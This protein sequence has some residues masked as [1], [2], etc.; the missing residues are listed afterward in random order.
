MYICEQVHIYMWKHEHV[1]ICMWRPNNKLWC[2]FSGAV[3][4]LIVWDM[5]SHWDLGLI[6]WTRL[7]SFGSPVILLAPPPHCWDYK[8]V[9]AHSGFL[10]RCWGMNSGPCTC[11]ARTILSHHPSPV[12]LIIVK[13][14]PMP[15]FA[16]MTGMYQWTSYGPSFIHAHC[17]EPATYMTIPHDRKSYILW[18]WFGEVQQGVINGRDGDQSAE[19]RKT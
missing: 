11:K 9:P 3:Y 2:H 1:C 19:T 15:N 16:L 10:P 18:K 17:W 6:C 4:N 5:F 13:A 7:V 14:C 12:K 8:C